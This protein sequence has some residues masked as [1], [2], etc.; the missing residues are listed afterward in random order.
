MFEY[1]HSNMKEPEAH[2]RMG[3]ATGLLIY[4]VINA[5]LPFTAFSLLIFHTA[6]RKYCFMY[7]LLHI[8]KKYSLDNYYL[9]FIPK[10]SPSEVIVFDSEGDVVFKN[11]IAREN[12]TTINS[13]SQLGIVDSKSLIESGKTKTRLFE[14]DENKYQL[15]IKGI[16]KEK[17]I[18][19][20]FS[21]VT[22]MMELRDEIETTQAEVIYTM[23]EIGETRSQET[24]NHV[25]RVALY[26]EKLALLY[27]LPK[28]EAALLRM[29]S[30][31]HDIGKVAI[32]DDILNAPRKLTDEEFEVMKTHTTLGHQMLSGSK[33]KTFQ[34]AAIVAHEHHEK[35]DGSGY[36]QALKGE[37]IHI[38]G[39]ITALVDVFDAL[40]SERVYKGA[41]EMNDILALFYKESGKH[42]D[43]KLVSLFVANLDTF[44]AIHQRY[45]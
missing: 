22:Q 4:A 32:P 19:A 15:E 24:G 27:G 8:N 16:A 39:R 26:S 10:E 36:P 41:W 6:Y 43:P 30:P 28:E 44:L 45:R 13:L 14:Q 7:A 37:D 38:F 18:L 34:A 3:I 1:S 35:F 21:N 2:A 31:M 17:I 42:F 29:A 20:Y 5:S 23:G 11:T 9:S 12:L 25:K 40:I 33:Q